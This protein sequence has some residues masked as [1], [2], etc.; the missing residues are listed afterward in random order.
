M[1]AGARAYTAVVHFENP[2]NILVLLLIAL[3]VL[4]PRRLPEAGRALGRGL[5]EFRDSL[6]GRDEQE[7]AEAP[8]VE[9]PPKPPA[10]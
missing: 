4:G 8:A 2:L 6:S 7:A 1:G 5:R 9:A 3:L 10:D